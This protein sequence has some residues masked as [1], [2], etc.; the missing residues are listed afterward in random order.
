MSLIVHWLR[1]SEIR[2]YFIFQAAEIL[3]V[4]SNKIHVRVKRLGGG[5]GGKETRFH[6][7]ANPVV[8]AA[9]KYVNSRLGKQPERLVVKTTAIFRH[10]CQFFTVWANIWIT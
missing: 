5:F 8:I 10:F 4:D 2:F 9:N 7:L 3:G 6:V 1:F